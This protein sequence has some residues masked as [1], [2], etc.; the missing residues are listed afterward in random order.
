MS[1]VFGCYARHSTY[2]HI[3]GSVAILTHNRGG[4]ESAELGRNSVS[5]GLAADMGFGRRRMEPKRR[6]F[7]QYLNRHHKIK[8]ETVSNSSEI[9]YTIEL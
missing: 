3:G 2:E 7:T 4:I 1:H 5:S 9:P 8:I 6:L